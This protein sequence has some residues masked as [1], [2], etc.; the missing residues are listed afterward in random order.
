MKYIFLVPDGAADLPLAE[1][2]D[3]TVLEA[4]QLPHLDRLAAEGAGGTALTVPDGLPAGSDVANLALLGYDP[5]RYYTGRGPLEAASLGVTAEPDEVI[6][7]CNLI[8]I[9][10]GILA[11]Y[12]SGHV[13]T[14]EAAE[15]I[16][17]LQRELGEPGVRFHAGMSYRHLLVLQGDMAGIRCVPPHDVVGRPVAEVLPEG[18]EANHLIGIMEDARLV[19]ENHRVNLE[20]I[21][22]GLVPANAIWPWGQ[23]V[24]PELP[25]F[26]EQRG[27][28]GAVITAVDL[29]K[30]LA[31]CAGLKVLE[32][33][34]A[35]GYYDTDYRAKA[36]YALAALRECD[37][38]FVHVEASDE[39]GHSGDV[40]E[41][42]LALERFDELLAGRVL[43][44]LAA[45]GTPARILVAPDHYTPLSIRTHTAGPVPFLLWG[46]GIEPDGCRDFSEAEM[47]ARG[48]FGER[49]GWSL[50]D[51]LFG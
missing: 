16:G 48:A 2:G 31:I 1:L 14:A 44:G 21:E 29:L 41:K 46:A 7:R 24:L 10:N 40:A 42:I 38:V 27:V 43:E 37:F 13:T 30:G 39:A 25:A 26:P 28:R 45:A 18:P 8:N 35:T 51:L 49:E 4:A 5:R 9:D 50:L 47:E 20:R 6:F 32:V 33:P 3:R 15:L 23:G 17:A 22:R 34:G 12:S 36:E 19:L 11:D